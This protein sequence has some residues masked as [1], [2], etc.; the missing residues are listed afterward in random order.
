MKQLKEYTD[1][2]LKAFAFDQ[3]A[4]IDVAKAN[5]RV[6]NEEL[7]SRQKPSVEPENA[8]ESDLKDKDE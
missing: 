8:P 1:T 6:I 2:E 7:A 3:I 5:L 4:N